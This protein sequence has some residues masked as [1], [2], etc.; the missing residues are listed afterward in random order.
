MIPEGWLSLP[1]GSVC[2]SI[3]PGR[4]KPSRFDGDIPWITTPNI[5]KKYI[6]KDSTSLLVSEDVL[7]QCGGKIVPEGAVVI[8]CVG[9]FGIIGIAQQS[10]VINQQLHA[11]VCPANISNEYI[12]YA[13]SMRV[14]HMMKMATT[15][16]IPYMNK[17][18]CES[19]P[20]NV[21]P[22]SEQHKIAEI[23]GAWDELIDLLI[24]TIVAKRKLKQ[25]L[26]QQ[27]LTGDRRF[28][29]FEGS[30]WSVVKVADF[31]SEI[32]KKN[33][34]NENLIP[35]S[36]SKVYGIV[37]QTQIFEK[38]IASVDTRRY[39]IVEKGDLVYD[40]MLLWDAS[41]GFV[42][43]VDR[44]TI[45][46]AYNTF[47]LKSELNV[48]AYF[49]YLLKSH[50]FREMYKLIS[51]GTNVRRRK[52]PA[53]DFLNIEF[54][55]PTEIAEQEKIAAVLS[56][57]DDEITTLETQL[58]AVKQQKRGLMQQ[59]LTGKKRVKV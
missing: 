54:D 55:F 1:I 2:K 57:A 39:K 44:G 3:V 13:L 38:R 43:S 22:L 17:N 47:Q 12:F 59:L 52:A 50:H 36:C 46:P 53:V 15:T 35:L 45:S 23:L 58:T 11:F 29:E 8:N 18:S 30:E 33:V 34:K 42:E 25:G 19:I 32:S 9:D 56:A 37:P 48:Q 10:L 41:I 5:V 31:F 24:Q 40:P 28:K 21:P 14:K 51:Q 6:H 7:K 27:L 16:T 20:I 49:R 4:N 26:M